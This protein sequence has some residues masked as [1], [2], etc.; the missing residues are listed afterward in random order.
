MY[1]LLFIHQSINLSINLSIYLS[2]YLSNIRFREAAVVVNSVK[3]DKFPLLLSKLAQKLHLRAAKVFSETEESQ[4]K[5][6]FSLDDSQL[7][8]VLSCSS[9]VFEQAAFQ[10]VGPEPLAE[11][12]IAAGIDEAHAKVRGVDE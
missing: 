3:L 2:I 9:Y 5:S 4:L 8:L 10:G 1:L 7:Q 12:L 6:L 11:A